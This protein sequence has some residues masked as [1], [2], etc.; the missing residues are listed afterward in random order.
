[1]NMAIINYQEIVVK[2]LLALLVLCVVSL[3]A[4]AGYVQGYY[5]ADGTYVQPYYRS[6][7][8]GTVTDNYGYQGNVN[9]YTGA[10]G[11]SNYPHDTTSPYYNGTPYSNGQYGH[12]YGQQYGGN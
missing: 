10:I 6:E 11:H 8:N 7:P 1:M 9:P 4:H 2:K 12:P 5:R 3:P